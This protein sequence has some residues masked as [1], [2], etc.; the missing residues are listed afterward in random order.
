MQSSK[1]DKYWGKSHNLDYWRTPAPEVLAFINENLPTNN[2]K[3]LDLG[4]GLGRHS[5]AFAEQG[6]QVTAV[7]YSKQAL[8]ELDSISQ[9]NSLIIETILGNYKT[10]VFSDAE[11]DIILSYNVLYH[12]SK[13]EFQSSINLCSDYLADNGRFMFTCPTRTD[14]KYGS[15]IKVAEHTYKS[16]NSVHAGDIHYFS[17]EEDLRDML[18]KFEIISIEKNEFHW[19][20]KATE[21]FSS[22]WIV[23]VMKV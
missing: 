20:N 5:L 19:M 15:G 2:K 16:E 17:S 13:E 4:C 7:D 21:Q 11:F 22:Y 3:I 12:G 10:R 8:D 18:K 6:F 9:K 1:W 23:K 14:E